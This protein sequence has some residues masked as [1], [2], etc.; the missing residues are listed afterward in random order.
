MNL[1]QRLTSKLL[2]R[3]QPAGLNALDGKAGW[4]II[5]GDTPTQFQATGKNVRIEGWERHPVVMA[6]TRLVAEIV[7]SVPFE[8]YSLNADGQETVIPGHAL[9]K[10]L[11]APFHNMSGFRF[12]LLSTLHYLLYGNLFWLLDRGNIDL[13]SGGP[14]PLSTAPVQA[15]RLLH[16][17]RVAYVYTDLSDEEPFL[18]D[19]R[20]RNGT[21]HRSSAADI[22]HV[23]DMAGSDWIFGFPRAATALKDIS[24][25]NAASDYVRQII[26]ND[27][28]PTMVMIMDQDLGAVTREELDAASQRWYERERVRGELGRARFLTS[29]KD[30]K[31]FGFNL[32]ELEFPAL[33]AIAREDICAV[34]GVDPRMVGIASA[35]GAE[36]GLSGQQYFE[37]RF[38]LIQQTCLPLMHAIESEINIWL[39][40]EF[41]NVY[42][43]FSQQGLDD[44]TENEK[45]TW[46]RGT[47]A[48]SAG[49][50]TREEFRDMI[51]FDEEMED[52]EHIIMPTSSTVQLVSEADA[53]SATK[54]DQLQNPPQPL[55][56]PN[57][58]GDTSG[59]AAGGSGAPKAL[60]AGNK[61]ADGRPAAT[62]AAHPC[63][64]TRSTVMSPELR[65]AAWSHVDAE[66]RRLEPK[67]VR[68]AK[69][70]FHD[71]AKSVDKIF[72]SY[73]DRS[74]PRP[75]TRDTLAPDPHI[76]EAEKR[77]LANYR[78]RGEY[79]KQWLAD[80]KQLT[81]DTVTVG[82]GDLAATL[83]VDFNLTDPRIAQIVEQ[84]ATRLVDFVTKTTAEQIKTAVDVGISEGM[85]IGDIADLI[86]A[87]V[88][89][90]MSDARAET[91]ART[92]TIGALNQSAQA[93]ASGS[94]VVDTKEWLTQGDD[95][96]R[97]SHAA[98]DGEVVGIDET[99][100]N[101]LEFPGDAENGDAEDVINCR[102]AQLFSDEEVAADARSRPDR[103][104]QAVTALA[105]GVAAIAARGSETTVI[106]LPNGA[107]K[108][109][110]HRNEK[111]EVTH[112]T[113]ESE[114]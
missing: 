114:S 28:T 61:K 52:D 97:D 8:V 45:D 58:Q 6:C 51:G 54:L 68:K 40:P 12:R 23:A 41:G 106:M 60:P 38:R 3:T 4:S 75:A 102:C 78:S 1:L 111:G 33:R 48:M 20:D 107:G 57:G 42:A 35:K 62:R 53:A 37:A 65:A 43:R 10:L 30:V 105:S 9:A 113:R 64:V 25:D 96:V 109:G 83:G 19:W 11:D 44:L 86:Q 90:G 70:Q 110:V 34:F 82:A 77:I 27:G 21:M 94:G 108:I 103:L 74:T 31:Q 46:L 55:A 69:L 66:A 67:Y 76:A 49:G 91:I 92:E 50:I 99:Y 7:A 17:E 26:K 47:A 93:A 36:G 59:T 95:R 72:R 98:I 56:L 24:T 80:Y 39:A 13:R 81:T 100:S 104:E 22:L 71:E 18:W 29:V 5:R 84:R 16:P 89:G 112:Y 73:A 88:F 32:R 14:I 2:T 101:G 87:S 63:L 15:L 85:G 79:Y